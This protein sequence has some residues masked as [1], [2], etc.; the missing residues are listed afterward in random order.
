MKINFEIEL[1]DA[2]AREFFQYMRDFDTNYDP[3]HEGKIKMCLTTESQ[4][5]VEEMKEIFQ[6][7]TPVPEFMQEFKL[8]S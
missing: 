2:L 4:Q 1:P 6:S 8:D 5:S 7:I 3:H